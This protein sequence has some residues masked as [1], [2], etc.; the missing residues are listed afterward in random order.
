MSNGSFIPGYRIDS[1]DWKPS[2]D[3]EFDYLKPRKATQEA[4]DDLQEAVDEDNKKDEPERNCAGKAGEFTNYDDPRNLYDRP[5]DRIAKI[6]CE[7]CPLFKLCKDYARAAKPE[8]GVWAGK[9][10]GKELEDD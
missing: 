9:V 1:R 8:W 7:G 4:L 6:M 10:Y 5:T 3:R 2:K